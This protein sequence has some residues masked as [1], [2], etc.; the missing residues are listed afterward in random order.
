MN[1][2]DF[3]NQWNN[4]FCEVSDPSN[5]NQCYDLAI[6]YCNALGIPKSAI[7]HLYAYQIYASPVEDTYLNFYRIPNTPNAT[8]RKG[9]MVVWNYT[10]NGG[11]GHVG[12]CTGKA[13]TFTFDAFEQNDPLKSPCHVKNYNYSDV[14]GWLRPIIL[15]STDTSG[16]QSQI[17][18]L[19]NKINAAKTALG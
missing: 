19:Q 4:K 2:D 13:D 9:D 16:L 17:T 12:I 7:A 8:P 10:Y 1:F 6:A 11:A 5:L 3:Y 18:S 14:L 15:T